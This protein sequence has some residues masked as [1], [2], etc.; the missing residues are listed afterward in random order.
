MQ[1]QQQ[2]SQPAATQ[3]EDDGSDN[4]ILS[5]ENR[6]FS[7][8][9]AQHEPLSQQQLEFH[10]PANS[11]EA[12]DPGL[13]AHS[14][15]SSAGQT[16]TR[17][18]R[19]SPIAIVRPNNE[20]ANEPTG[21]ETDADDDSEVDVVE[22]DAIRLRR[23]YGDKVVAASSYQPGMTNEANSSSM[24]SKTML[25]APYLGS[26]SKAENFLKSLPPISLSDENANYHLGEPPSEITSYGSLRES[27][28][29]GKF[30]D[31]PSSYREPRS[32]QIRR[33]DHRLRAGPSM[34]TSHQPPLSIGERIEQAQRQKKEETGDVVDAGG[35]SRLAMMMDKAS[36]NDSDTQRGEEISELDSFNLAAAAPSAASHELSAFDTDEIENY[37]KFDPPNMMATSLTAF[38]VL[39]ASS[40]L[41][42][43]YQRNH[44][45][46]FMQQQQE[47]STAAAS[48]RTTAP[49]SGLP[50]EREV[51]EQHFQ[52]LSRSL[53][54]PTPH[55]LQ[56]SPMIAPTLQQLNSPPVTTALVG[57]GQPGVY[58][59]TAY[60]LGAMAQPGVQHAALANTSATAD[61]LIDTPDTDAAFDMDME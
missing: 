40:Q 12:Y 58:W 2:S 25:K 19:S 43:G 45:Q 54:D 28:Q 47:Q 60:G 3:Q 56:R 46:R 33:L 53:S 1:Q 30:L 21:F 34:S 51:R 23:K 61:Q 37:D 10:R 27:H 5:Q 42:A 26:L 41:G 36:K 9:G 38:E 55:H 4:D 16:P 14:W 18:L 57:G 11:Q 49:S 59:A 44:T 13:G 8:Y 31:G 6:A 48:T 39:H 17:Q 52:P 15:S 32:G 24:F 20:K 7:E 50:S 29:R 22:R 35:A